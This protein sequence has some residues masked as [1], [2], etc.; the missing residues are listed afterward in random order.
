MHVWWERQ[1]LSDASGIDKLQYLTLR[2]AE[3]SLEG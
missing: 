3:S 1:Q 2:K